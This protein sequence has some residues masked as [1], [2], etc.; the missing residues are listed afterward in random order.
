MKIKMV[1]KIKPQDVNYKFKIKNIKE[2]DIKKLG[3]VMLGAYRDTIDYEG[4]TLED[5]Q[6]EIRNVI[7]GGYGK[8]ISEASFLIEFDN[9]I[10]SA[11]FTNM[12]EGNPLI[13][14]T[15]TLKK[16]SNQGM[17]RNLILKSIN[18]LNILGYKELYLFVTEGNINAIELYQ[19]IG[20]EVVIKG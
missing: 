8:L 12:F 6:K 15:F 5:S 18:S 19:K 13:T 4:E 11:I 9:V 2:K 3:S 1:F 14:Y 16:Y 17:A 10:T 20:F 7:K